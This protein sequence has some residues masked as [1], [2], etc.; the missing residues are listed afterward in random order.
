MLQGETRDKAKLM[1]EISKKKL[2]LQQSHHFEHEVCLDV[3]GVDQWN[4][5]ME[6]ANRLKFSEGESKKKE[7]L[8]SN[9]LKEI[10]KGMRNSSKSIR[11]L[12]LDFSS[13]DKIREKDLGYL[14]KSSQIMSK[15][16]E[17]SLNLGL[18]NNIGAQR[19]HFLVKVLKRAS[20]LETLSL[21]F[22][23]CY[24]LDSLGASRLF[25]CIQKLLTLKTLKLK[26]STNVV[27]EK[28]F[29]DLG[30]CL[31]NL[32]VLQKL[33]LQ[34]D[35]TGSLTEESLI[36]LSQCFERMK[37]LKTLYLSFRE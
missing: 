29:Q 2:F 30:D 34:F 17:I 8:T 24:G 32:K 26:F 27:E 31:K 6:K 14:F 16:K 12:D 25:K 21:D 3:K 9:R 7:R 1:E 13:C 33:T 5:K 18:I 15:L 10:S 35:R 37:N 36:G 20:L 4:K 22:Y 28:G 19:L 23:Q 11:H